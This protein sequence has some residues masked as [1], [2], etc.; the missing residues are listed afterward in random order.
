MDQGWWALAW[1][2]AYDLTG[3]KKFLTAAETIFQNNTKGWDTVCGGGTYWQ[4]NHNGP[5][6]APSYKNAIANELFLAIAAALYLRLKDETYLKR[7]NDEWTWF[8]KSGLDQ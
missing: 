6:G 7:A 1:I 4:K 3:D 8:Q 5:D 2:K